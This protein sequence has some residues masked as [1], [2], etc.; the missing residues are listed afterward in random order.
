[1]QMKMSITKVINVSRV[2]SWY[3][4]LNPDSGSK[5]E[6]VVVDMVDD[7]CPVIFANKSKS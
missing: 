3:W 2:G 5:D 1:M 7:N 6:A 4:H